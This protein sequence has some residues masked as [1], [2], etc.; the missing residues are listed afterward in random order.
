MTSLD[1]SDI[2]ISD[3]LAQ[4]QTPQEVAGKAHQRSRIRLRKRF[5]MLM[6]KRRRVPTVL[7]MSVEECGATCLAMILAYY[8][9]K[10][11]IAEIREQC[12]IGRDG[13]SAFALVKAAQAY[14]L[15]TRAIT[16]ESQDFRFLTLPAIIHWNLDRK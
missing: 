6:G 12:G 10:I 14:G 2:I 7:Q 1:S 16:L 4:M 15:R 9:R 5:F 11:T 13:I 3:S 8:G